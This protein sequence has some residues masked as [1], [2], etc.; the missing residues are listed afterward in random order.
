MSISEERPQRAPER[1]DRCDAFPFHF[2]VERNRGLSGFAQRGSP[3]AG[4][5]PL[6]NDQRLPK[7]CVHRADELP[8]PHVR[9][10][11]LLGGRPNR[12]VALNPLEKGGLSRAEHDDPPAKDAE[13]G[14]DEGC[15][16]PACRRQTLP[17]FPLMERPRSAA[18]IPREERRRAPRSIAAPEGIGPWPSIPKPT[19]GNLG[20]WPRTP[21][22]PRAGNR[23]ARGPVRTRRRSSPR[24][25][26]SPAREP[27][28]R[29]SR[30]APQTHP[31]RQ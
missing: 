29:R 9:H 2:L 4:S 11:H 18:A 30:G 20:I 12:S 27:P 7:A 15:G 10:A 24:A 8:S 23:C 26:S 6:H 21:D 28:F 1:I 17:S 31:G 19:V 16:P 22:A 5:P 14:L 25:P 13:P 3:A